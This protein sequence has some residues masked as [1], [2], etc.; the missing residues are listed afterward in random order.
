MKNVLKIIVIGFAGG[1]G[2]SFAFYSWFVKP[3]LSETQANNQFSTVRYD[4]PESSPASATSPPLADPAPV[5]F[6]LAASRATQSVVFINSISQGS[7]YSYWDWFFGDGSGGNRT[8]VSSGSGVIFSADGYIV[9]N[10]HVIESAER[11]EVN[12]NKRVYTA[13][14]VG[15][16]PS[17]DLAVIKINETGLQ[18]IVLGNAKNIRVGEWV[19]AVGN[20]FTLSSTVTAGIVSAKGRRIGILQDKFPIESF[21]QTD[22]A[23][24][25]GNSG[26]ALVNK[27][28]ELV[29]IN[30]AILS[31]TGSY[32]GYAF[33][34]PVDIAKKV[35]DDLVKYGITQKVFFG[36][37]VVDY[38]YEHAKKYDLNTNV[39]NFN[40]VLLEQLEK[41]GPAIQAGLQLG[42]V[43]TKVN[44]II[45]DSQSAFE[46]ALSYQNPG[47]KVTVTYIRNNKTLSTVVTLVNLNGTTEVIKRKI[48]PAN[49]LGAQLESTQYGVKV[50]KIKNNSVLKQI[51]V[52]ENF[53]IIAI[54]RARVQDPQEIIDFFDKFKGR[55]YLYGVTSSKQQVEIPFVV[56]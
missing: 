46:E 42:D 2:G 49:E 3:V 53:T 21:I 54:N 30:T 17:T 32:T 39:K 13:E 35:F 45:I 43:I 23:I 10:N 26:G 33:A 22:A 29:G 40:G 56:R 4:A 25:P 48:I 18:P 12:Y 20:P 28:G 7:S 24:N 16:D 38:D 11:I 37:S 8:Q 44:S 5:D 50:F 47:D 27:N 6:S 52:P 36:G 15:T 19:V 31:R 34:V 51:G 1:F 9:T 55:G 14:L 41:E